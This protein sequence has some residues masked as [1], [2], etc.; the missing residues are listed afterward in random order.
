MANIVR[1]TE[2]LKCAE[3]KSDDW[4]SKTDCIHWPP[5]EFIEVSN[6]I[7]DEQ[8]AC[9]GGLCSTI[10][11]YVKCMATTPESVGEISDELAGLIESAK[12][13]GRELAVMAATAPALR[14]ASDRMWSMTHDLDAYFDELDWDEAMEVEWE[15]AGLQSEED[16]EYG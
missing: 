13:L 14:D 12:N 15:E 4:D 10:D 16:A 9:Y 8:G 1:C 6:D 7:N 3:M 5:H 2:Y 11:E